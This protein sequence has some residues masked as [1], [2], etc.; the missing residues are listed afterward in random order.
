VYEQNGE[1]WL[2]KRIEEYVLQ[3]SD[4]PTLTTSPTN[5]DMIHISKQTNYTNYN[6]ISAS[7]IDFIFP[8]YIS[9]LNLA[10]TY[11]DINNVNKVSTNHNFA[12]FRLYV[13]KGKYAN[14]AAAQA[15]LAGTVVQYQLAT[16]QLINLTQEGKVDGELIAF[17][18]GTI[19]NTSDT[20]HAD[21]SFD[22]ASNR[23]AQIT[24]LL[25]S[26]SYQAKQIDTKANKVQEDWIEPTLINGWVNT[27]TTRISRYYKDEF[28]I[29]HLVLN[30]KD[31]TSTALTKIL[32]LPVGYRPDQSTKGMGVRFN[33]GSLS[34]I[35]ISNAGAVEIG[36]NN[37]TGQFEFHAD[38]KVG[39]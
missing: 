3:A 38:F 33:D 27:A 8:P 23:S 24:G 18:N 37:G 32:D 5:V 28:G 1:I 20:F 39:E 36:L 12:Q 21:I 22:V 19:Y 29:V 13:T 34:Y 15:D 7:T 30:I 26:A 35:T 11:D 17:E 16:P 6:S 2:E 10:A 9:S 4:I 25:E 31:G 14:L